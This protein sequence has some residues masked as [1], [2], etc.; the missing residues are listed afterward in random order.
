MLLFHHWPQAL[1]FLSPVAMLL[2]MIN[3]ASDEKRK[4]LFT[5]ED[6]IGFKAVSDAQISP[7]GRHIAFVQ[8]DAYKSDTRTPKSQI[9]IV[10]D[11]GTGPRPLTA[12]PRTDVLPRWSPDGKLLA[13]ASD[14]LEDGQKQILLLPLEGGEAQ[15]LTDIKGTIPTPRGLNALQWSPDGRYLA[16]LK[17]DAQTVEEKFKIEQKDDAIE[18]EKAHKYVRLWVVEVS[19]RKIH[20]A[21]PEGLQV[22]EFGWSPDSQDMAATVSD[23]PY[24]WSWYSNRLARFPAAGGS[25]Q[26]LHRSRRQV[27]LPRWSPDGSQIGFLSSFWSDRG[28]TAGDI[29]T[30]PAGGGS[31][32]PLTEGAKASFGWIEWKPDSRSLLAVAHEQGGMSVSEIELSTRKRKTLWRGEVA[33]AESHWPRFS[34]AF[35]EWAD[36]HRQGA[37]STARIAVVR[38]DG[39]HPR[40]VWV[41]ESSS[42]DPASWRQLSWL[43]PQTAELEIATSES[44]HW[45]GAHGWDMQGILV[46]PVSYEKGKR[47]PLVTWVHGGPASASTFRYPSDGY[48]QLLAAKGMAVFLPN[49]RGSVGWGVKFAESNLGDLGGRDFEDIMAGIDSCVASGVADPNRLGIGGWSYGGFMSAWAV[50]QTT[51]FKAA[52]MGAGICNWLSFHGNSVLADWDAMHLNADPYEKDGA[53][54]RFSAINY[55]KRIQTPT[56]ILHGEKDGDVPPEQSYQFFRALKD[57]KVDTEL[58]IYPREG[59]GPNEKMHML[60]LARRIPGWFEKYLLGVS[61][62]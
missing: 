38:E 43:H 4:R 10:R 22:W 29:L 54:Q 44:I 9:W 45:K 7:D 26:T 28:V 11:E 55:A 40:D 30:I 58:V 37:V 42:E 16:F 57:H 18:F 6:A 48:V 34:C 24:E 27:A 62:S 32:L 56:L 59:H 35:P 47:Y 17:E 41:M 13:F 5:P 36:D 33:L 50:S 51:R 60:D 52:V 21:S 49:Y 31:V 15:P 3:T 8:G 20:C 19:S 14:R 25:A 12:G 1:L 39:S 61:A 2:P 46:K 23:L 53:Y